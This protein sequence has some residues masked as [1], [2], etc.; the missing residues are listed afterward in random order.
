MDKLEK[1]VSDRDAKIAQQRELVKKAEATS[2]MTQASL[3]ADLADRAAR[4]REL[5][6]G[7]AHGRSAKA[8]LAE[9][10]L[11]MQAKVKDI[12]NLKESLAKKEEE[13][14][15]TVSERRKALALERQL[16]E[17]DEQLKLARDHAQKA[18]TAKKK[19]RSDLEANIAEKDARIRELKDQL[20]AVQEKSPQ[21]P[22][23]QDLEMQEMRA[24]LEEKEKQLE[25]GERQIQVMEAKMEHVKSS[26]K[27]V[28]E[29]LEARLCESEDQI[30]K[31]EEELASATKRTAAAAAVLDKAVQAGDGGCG[32]REVRNNS[33]S[34]A[35]RELEKLRAETMMKQAKNPKFLNFGIA[36]TSFAAKKIRIPFYN[37]GK[38]S[39]E[40]NRQVSPILTG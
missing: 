27:K 22:K 11:E 2:R 35:K 13:A 15:G 29:D 9:M 6:A 28:K 26:K 19:V 23:M 33:V 10:D 32:G 21:S 40:A 12:A 17:R 4:I 3:E 36:G 1:E 16:A 7:Q 38:C 20:F 24:Q 30:R 37:Y 8:K 5:E 18:E 39:G 25:D 31:L 14:K 34:E